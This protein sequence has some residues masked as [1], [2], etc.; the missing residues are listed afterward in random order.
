MNIDIARLRQLD[1][2]LWTTIAA[3]AVVVLAAPLVSDFRLNWVTF[4][5]PLG[6]LAGLI[7]GM[8]FYELKRTDARLA[9]ALSGT[10]QIIAFYAFGAPLS[11]LAAS[12]GRP[13]QDSVFDAAGIGRVSMGSALLVCGL[14][15]EL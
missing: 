15:Q 4:G 11:Y 13:L 14:N 1:L 2:F 9:S 8:L 12:A 5:L 10:G 3:A 7:A 6:A